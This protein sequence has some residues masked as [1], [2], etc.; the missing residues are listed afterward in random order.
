VAQQKVSERAPK[1]R[2]DVVFF[3]V[4]YKPKT[5]FWLWP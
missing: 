4:G 3:S 1:E 5:G 2:R